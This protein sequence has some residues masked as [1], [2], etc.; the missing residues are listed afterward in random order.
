MASEIDSAGNIYNAI[1]ASANT[2]TVV[3]IAGSSETVFSYSFVDETAGVALYAPKLVVDGTGCV[4]LAATR[5]VG[6]ARDIVVAKIN[7]TGTSLLWTQTVTAG[8]SPSNSAYPAIQIN[9]AGE[10]VVLYQ[11]IAPSSAGH[12]L[13]IAKLQASS[14]SIISNA[15]LQSVNTPLDDRYPSL[16]IEGGVGYGAFQTNTAPVPTVTT[17]KLTQD[18]TDILWKRSVPLS[19]T[20]P[21]FLEGTPVLTPRGYR[22][23][24]TLKEGDEVIAASGTP[25]VI[26]RVCRT[27]TRPTPGT[28]PYVIPKGMFGA[29]RRLLIS[30]RHCVAVRGKG[31]VE[32]RYLGL[33]QWTMRKPFIYYN[34][35]LKE[36]VNMIV[37]G[38]E[39]ES[40][41]HKRTVMFT[42]ADFYALLREKGIETEGGTLASFIR[43]NC[44]IVG[45]N[46]IQVPLFKKST[47]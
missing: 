39:V 11:A 9:A 17:F 36:C 27:L 24:E 12:D 41:A 4:Y 6:G 31:M 28:N 38:V 37:C 16:A 23:I 2:I 15:S 44:Q 20:P 46:K 35:E 30:P 8:G 29:T 32:A 25:V 42:L 22:R 10:I 47:R 13:Y 7:N 1:V 3:K 18:T 45:E 14:G 5:V 26:T 19:E 43:R 21:C 33:K 40:L 34:L